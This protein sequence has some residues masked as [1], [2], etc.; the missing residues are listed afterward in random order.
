MAMKYSLAH[1]GI[2][3]LDL[4]RSVEFYTKAFDMHEVFRM[5]P[6]SELDMILCFLSDEGDTTEIA[7]TWYGERDIPYELGENDVHL[8]FVVDDFKASYEKHKKMGIVCI[9]ELKKD[10]Y[11]VEDP[12]GYQ[13]AIVP[14][15]YHPTFFTRRSR[16]EANAADR[17]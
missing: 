6:K 16:R 15:R 5:H 3:V 14:D 10:I 11:Y 8:V 2:N 7:L 1:I 17:A 12:D 13:I 4:S 9:E